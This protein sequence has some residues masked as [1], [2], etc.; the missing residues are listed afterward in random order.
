MIAFSHPEHLLTY[1]TPW[2][3]APCNSEEH[4]G[5]YK[6]KGMLILM[7]AAAVGH[8]FFLLP[9]ISH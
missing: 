9:K 3:Y 8:F 2:V 1:Q 6:L 7:Q 4:S 5:L